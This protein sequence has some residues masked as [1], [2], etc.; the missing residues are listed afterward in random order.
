MLSDAQSKLGSQHAA[1]WCRLKASD[2][3][4]TSTSYGRDTMVAY[5]V[6]ADL[7]R[8]MARSWCH[9]LLSRWG[10]ASPAG[11]QRPPVALRRLA[12]R[13]R[14][15]QQ[16]VNAPRVAPDRAAAAMQA[17]RSSP[18]AGAVSAPGAPAE[19]RSLAGVRLLAPAPQVAAEPAA[20]LRRAAACLRIAGLTGADPPLVGGH[21][22][23]GP[24]T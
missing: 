20:G 1:D 5:T 16:R 13:P 15:A 11:V 17:A 21:H 12:S 24:A 10:P 18:Q 9:Q 2:L 23:L 3:T 14:A 7:V 19:L 4:P 8:Q 6:A 22:P